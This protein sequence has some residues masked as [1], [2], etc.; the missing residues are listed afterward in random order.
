MR[1]NFHVYEMHVQRQSYS[2][3]AKIAQVILMKKL[4]IFCFL[5][6]YCSVIAI[7]VRCYRLDNRYC[8]GT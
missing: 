4:F 8:S 5:G 3:Y 7:E 1:K 2:K 6:V